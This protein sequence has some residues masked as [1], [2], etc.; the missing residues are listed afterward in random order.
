[1]AAQAAG[2]S[3]PAAARGCCGERTGEPRGN[4]SPSRKIVRIIGDTR[5]A[6][7]VQSK[8]III[9]KRF[10]LPL[11]AVAS[12]MLGTLAPAAA[13]SAPGAQGAPSGHHGNQAFAKMLMDLNLTD[14]QKDKIRTIMADAR[15]KSQTLTD[16]Q[17]KRD[18]YRA[19]FAKIETV[20]TPAQQK[21]LQSERDA[22]K[23]QHASAATH[24]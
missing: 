24:S 17:A 6:M 12:I 22:Y 23:A 2:F 13:Q 19:A 14:V 4:G 5:R 3:F 15:T 9:M 18:N 1:M 8:E 21:K 11:V 20:L 7:P 10:V 16:P